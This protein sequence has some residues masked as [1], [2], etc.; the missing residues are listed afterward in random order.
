MQS[1]TQKILHGGMLVWL[2]LGCSEPKRLDPV[3]T[4]VPLQKTGPVKIKK[5]D[6]LKQGE[7]EV[8]YLGHA[9]YAVRTTSRIL[10]FDCA[11]MEPA[12]QDTSGLAG[13]IIDLEELNGLN[14]IFFVSHDHPDHFNPLLF[15]A[16]QRQNPSIRWIVSSDVYDAIT[17]LDT[18][19]TNVIVPRLYRRMNIDGMIVR[20]IK[21][22]DGGVAYVV[23]VD[24]LQL[25]FGGD[26]AWWAWDTRS[27]RPEREFKAEL[28]RLTGY[29]FDLA[30]L[31]I[32]PNLRA[33]DFAGALHFVKR[34]K[35]N[36][37]FPMHKLGDNASESIAFRN[38]VLET[39]LS[40]A[41]LVRRR[42]DFFHYVKPQ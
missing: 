13:G 7:A 31:P 38:A 11:L 8:W 20:G 22:N 27:K 14:T 29:R 37:V 5:F 2:T 33:Y 17:S 16:F 41:A 30:F 9:G 25:Y 23:Q 6:Q 26:H 32:D 40:N 3:S 28:D 19:M 42:G 24:G 18:V 34:F 4:F 21:S 36:M 15:V 12:K 1:S 35:P 39:G 10:I